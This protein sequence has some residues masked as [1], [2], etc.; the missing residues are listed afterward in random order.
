MFSSDVFHV[1]MYT[2][3][4]LMKHIFQGQLGVPQAFAFKE[5]VLFVFSSKRMVIIL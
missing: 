3:R 4:N 1:I 5:K 2:K